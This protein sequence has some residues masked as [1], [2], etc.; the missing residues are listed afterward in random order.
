MAKETIVK[1]TD[2][3][4]GSE[5]AQTVEFSYQGKFYEIDL[6]TKNQMAL[7][8]ALDKYIEKARA[9]RGGLA[10]ATR[11]RK[12]SSSGPRHDGKSARMRV[13]ASERGIPLKAK[14]RVPKEIE[15]QYDAAGGV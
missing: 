14:G 5:D 15:D 7:E 10:P 3:L 1:I 13:W 12:S 9:V 2:D 6:S 11:A 4:D 8:K